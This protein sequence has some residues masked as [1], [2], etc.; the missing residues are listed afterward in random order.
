MDL[1]KTQC[2]LLNDDIS[3]KYRGEKYFAV[4]RGKNLESLSSV[5]LEHRLA[6]TPVNL[7]KVTGS[8]HSF[9]TGM[10]HN[11]KPL[12]VAFVFNRMH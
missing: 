2:N 10:F 5:T 6:K 4:S 7:G 8:T 12:R 9:F 1:L 3:S 11:F